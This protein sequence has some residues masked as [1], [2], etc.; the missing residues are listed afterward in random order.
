MDIINLESLGWDSYFEEAFKEFP[1]NYRPGRILA[2]YKNSYRLLTTK[3]EV[4]GTISGKLHHKKR[5]PAVGDWVMVSHWSEGKKVTIE[6]ILPRKTKVS[7]KSPGKRFEEQVIV[8]NVD[9]I[10]IVT[11]LNRDFNLKRIERY[12]AIVHESGAKPVIILN[13]ADLCNDI[14]MKQEQ[15]EAL[16][17][18]VPIHVVS[19]LDKDGID[20]L[21]PYLEIGTTVALLGSSGVGKSTLINAITG[22]DTLRVQDVRETDDRGRHTTTHR[23]LHMLKNGGMVIDNP[24]MRE[25]QLLNVNEGLKGTFSNIEELA[26]L[27]KFKDCKH[28]T[29]PKCAVKKAVEDGTLPR[30]RLESYNKLNREI[31]Y[32]N[33]KDSLPSSRMADKAKWD[34]IIQEANLEDGFDHQE[35]AA[36]KRKLRKRGK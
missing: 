27:C 26:A 18:D 17:S 21:L 1:E 7:R 33:L 20:E 29:E 2:R 30:E 16:S 10:F 15:V 8:A 34:N 9:S 14:P 24:G 31:R 36:L 35:R 28:V 13:K 12:L 23:E 11:S 3:G 6:D 32:S 4:I 22:E 25:I 19:A 5:Y